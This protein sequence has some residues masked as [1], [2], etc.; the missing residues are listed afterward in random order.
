MDILAM[1][2]ICMS[3]VGSAVL[4]PGYNLIFIFF[5]FIIFYQYKKNAYMQESAYGRIKTPVSSLM[6]TSAMFGI[7]AGMLVSVPAVLLGISVSSDMGLQYVL[8]VSLLLMLIDP[9][10]ICFSYSGGIVS[11]A[12]LIFG[13]KSIDATG[14][15]IL[16]GLLH[17]LE[18][19]LVY[20][21]GYKGAVPV[22]LR[23]D[24][25]SVVGGFSMQR[26][27]PIPLAMIM[28]AG[29]NIKSTAGAVVTP[30]WWPIIKPY[31]NP[32]QLKDAM[33]TAMP[34]AA[35]LG[36]GE[37]TSSSTPV[38]KCRRT[39]L[40]LACFS[41]VLVALSFASSFVF[42]FKYI[43]AIFA[44]VGHEALIIWERRNE[45]LGEPIF[46]SG[47][48]GVKVLDTV[49]DGPADKMGIMPGDRIVSIN[50]RPVMSEEGMSSFL[51]SMPSYIWVDVVGSSGENRSLEY[52]DFKD[53]IEDLGVLTSLGNRN[54]LV[55][56]TEKK[57]VL[58]TLLNRL[59][60]GDR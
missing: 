14:I 28:F 59:K 50:S 58:A 54:N 21:D 53:P 19:I 27:W 49:P 16:V 39:S 29:L 44:P 17:L 55:L 24:D 48:F 4:I 56:M 12:G 1:L 35:M 42:A 34:V 33:F 60:G 43:A 30:G 31:L 20:F 18:S 52:M 37:F 22:L 32:P 8:L 9:R 6:I 47:K 45:Q 10:F 13:I 46:Q 5:L 15:M 3:T 11:L 2:K 7:A 41:I 51:S 23:R 57:S 38:Q 36:Y 40:K 25:G 26:F